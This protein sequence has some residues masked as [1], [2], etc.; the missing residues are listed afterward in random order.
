VEEFAHT[1]SNGRQLRGHV[2]EVKN[3]LSGVMTEEQFA[4]AL[5]EVPGARGAV[6]E[7]IAALRP[8][9]VRGYLGK[10]HP[11][12]GGADPAGV[13]SG[14]AASVIS[15]FSADVRN[16]LLCR[17]IAIRVSARTR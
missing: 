17:M 16:N 14:L 10:E 2:T 3:L 11:Q 7:R 6:W 12:T 5:A 9:T 13:D 15:T 1:F 4:G 8:D